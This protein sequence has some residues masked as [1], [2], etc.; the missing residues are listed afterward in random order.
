[1]NLDTATLKLAAVCNSTGLQVPARG[2]G[3]SF[4]NIEQLVQAI[5]AFVASYNQSA[6]SFVWRK[7]EVKGSQLRNTIIDLRN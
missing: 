2:A 4:T 6:S 3:A 7:R 1:M 5:E